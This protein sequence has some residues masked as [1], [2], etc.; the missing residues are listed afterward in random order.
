VNALPFLAGY[1]GESVDELLAYEGRYRIDSIVL[2]FEQAIQQ[3]SARLK[4]E[5]SDEERVVLA[6]EALERDVN[7]DGYDGFLRYSAAFVP[8]IVAALE[9]IG[10]LGVARITRDAI[11]AGLSGSLESLDQA[12]YRNPEDIEGRLFAFIA[13]N[14]ERFVLP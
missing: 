11:A 1:S 12:Y 9:R 14:R 6:V 13:A 8:V 5:C 3:R 7:N 4:S 10:C 2:A